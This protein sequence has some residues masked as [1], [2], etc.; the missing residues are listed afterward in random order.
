MHAYPNNNAEIDAIRA[1]IV[2][3]LKE[4]RNGNSKS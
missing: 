4:L 2:G 1:E 3:L